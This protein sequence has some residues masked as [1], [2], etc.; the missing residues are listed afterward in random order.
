MALI[1][2]PTPFPPR[3]AF[4]ASRDTAPK[5]PASKGF[6]D[7]DAAPKRAKK[8]ALEVLRLGNPRHVLLCPPS[9]YIDCRTPIDRLGDE[10]IQEEP[11]IFR[12]TYQGTMRGFNDKR[13]LIWTIPSER[14]P[15]IGALNWPLI[16]ATKRTEIDL[17]DAGGQHLVTS[18]FFAPRNWVERKIGE[19]IL[20]MGYLKRFGRNLSLEI[21]KEAPPR[22]VGAIWA[23]YTG[24]QGQLAGERIESLVNASVDNED[25]YLSCVASILGETG[26]NEAELMQ[27]CAGEH[28][29]AFEGCSELLRALHRPQTV[30]QGR[31]ALE[32][33]RRIT[34]LGIQASA[35]RH[36]TRHPHPK[37]P[38]PVNQAAAERVAASLSLVLT[39]GQKDVITQIVNRLA[40]PKPL[41]G[42]LSGDVGT[43]K[44]LAFL[45]PAVAAYQAGARVAII[46][47][48]TLLADQIAA[49]IVKHFD[50]IGVEVERVPTGGKIINP[51]AILV[52]THGL[53]TVASRH[54]YA[55]QMLIA[56]EQHKFSAEARE[57]LVAPYTHV[58]EVSATPV[59]RSLAASL[60]EGMEILNLRECP[61]QKKIFSEVVDMEHRFEVI[62]GVR[63]TIA[64]GGIAAM[65]YPVVGGDEESEGQSVTKAF[66]S[67]NDAFPG[68]VV[69]MHGEMSDEEMRQ[70]IAMLRSGEK[71]LVVAYNV[72]EIGIDIPSIA[73]MA[74][75]DADRFGISQLHQLRGR[76]VRNGG[77]GVFM[78]VVQDLATTPE[79]ALERL[80]C[81]VQTNDGY[82]LAEMDL[83]QR[84]F[85]D[86][87]GSAQSGA[88]IT[89][90]RNLKLKAGDF[91]ARKLKTVQAPESTRSYNET[92][93][94]SMP[95]QERLI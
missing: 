66:K 48:R 44:T 88:S 3:K 29:V 77:E 39:Q 75:R 24:I 89:I 78:M 50:H 45:V 79:S 76:L 60:Y 72:L 61:V 80:Q 53:A 64:N 49:E 17:K 63:H 71:Q 69:M 33:A 10:H 94:R 5:K 30:E 93:H 47:P 81:V 15:H 8:S 82:K 27:A 18:Q 1:T 68:K 85:G 55:P 41:N 4:E 35:I 31:M 38:L 14:V 13:A 22:A 9:D 59:P 28:P 54:N 57:S 84:G 32:Y 62:A 25:A 51:Q 87:D 46:T 26:L 92:A 58:L 36:H 70:N 86:L 2:S 73:F 6:K 16:K 91:L 74:V 42:L 19:E 20:A 12:V 67:L 37:A 56:D 34:A 43:G 21:T 90:F 65:I 11:A 52:G 40:Q 95:R 83:V 7:A 23:Q